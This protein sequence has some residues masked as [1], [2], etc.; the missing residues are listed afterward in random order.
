MHDKPHARVSPYRD[1]PE[2]RSR[3]ES[4]DMLRDG[5]RVLDRARPGSFNPER[6]SLTPPSF[7]RHD[8][9]P[10]IEDHDGDT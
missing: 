5:Y 2:R 4:G 7:G 6:R 9:Y 8:P 3:L 10:F 1:E